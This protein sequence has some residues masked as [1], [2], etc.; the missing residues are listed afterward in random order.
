MR[1]MIGEHR[2]LLEPTY[3]ALAGKRFQLSFFRNSVIYVFISEAIV[4]AVLY[5]RVKQ[6]GGALNQ[7]MPLEDVMSE[8]SWLSQLLAS[9]FVYAT[10]GLA[11]NAN[12][13]IA[14]M[15]KEKVLKVDAGYLGLAEEERASG[16]ERYDFSCFLLWPFIECVSCALSVSYLAR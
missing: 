1:D 11:A 3:Y 16:R 6:G 9:E 12:A 2:N 7:R 5:S 10:E 15:E 14:S 4:C 13:T 8:L